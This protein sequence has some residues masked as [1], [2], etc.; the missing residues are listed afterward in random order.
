MSDDVK[1]CAKARKVVVGSG[2]LRVGEDPK[3]P[4]SNVPFL[5]TLDDQL[6]RLPDLRGIHYVFDNWRREPSGCWRYTGR[7]VR[8]KKK[9]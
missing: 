8:E 2:L 7:K 6:R 1:L 9:R 3:N 4:D 5:E